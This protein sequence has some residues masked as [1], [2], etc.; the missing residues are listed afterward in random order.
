[1]KDLELE[2]TKIT[3]V[4]QKMK[5]D[6]RSLTI[7]I[8]NMKDIKVTF[9]PHKDYNT[10]KDIRQISLEIMKWGITNLT[11]ALKEISDK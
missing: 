9:N 3:K 5:V 7:S 10:K 1:M 2:R 4:L 11:L 8:Q 6:I